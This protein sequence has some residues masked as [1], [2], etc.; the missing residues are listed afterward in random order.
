MI[1]FGAFNWMCLRSPWRDVVLAEVRQVA[2]AIRPDGFWFDLLGAPNAYGVGSYDAADACFCSY[3]REAYRKA[4]DDEQP[5]AST[6]IEIRRRA[7]RFGHQVRIAM[8][9]DLVDLLLAIDAK[10]VLGH[11]GAGLWDALDGTPSSTNL[12]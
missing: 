1:A 4:F 12:G 8:L 10:M 2:E 6:D 9:R 11:N 5:A 3:C 7:N